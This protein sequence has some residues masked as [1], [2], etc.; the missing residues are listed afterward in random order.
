M[1]TIINTA[2][3]LIIIMF[4]FGFYFYEQFNLLSLDNLVKIKNM[5]K[6]G[7]KGNQG[8]RGVDWP[9]K[10]RFGLHCDFGGWNKYFGVGEYPNVESLGMTGGISSIEIPADLDMVGFS[11][12]N[13]KGDSILFKGSN[14]N[15]CL[16]SD[17]W[18]DRLKSIKIR[19]Q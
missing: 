2:L 10:I 16:V 12:Y 4:V 6:V 9:S 15:N 7:E 17:G 5:N 14:T 11:E 3:I 18:N 19:Q 13:F 8:L 1:N